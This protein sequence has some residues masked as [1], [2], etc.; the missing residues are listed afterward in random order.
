MKKIMLL[1]FLILIFGFLAG[2]Q[3]ENNNA[4]A[5]ETTSESEPKESEGL[6]IETELAKVELSETKGIDPIVYEEPDELELFI[7]IF[8]SAIREP[9]I[10]NMAAPE[11]Y[12]K[13]TLEDGDIQYLN[14]WLGDEEETASLMNAG[15][16]HTLYTV[17]PDKKRELVELISK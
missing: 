10:V 7:D 17:T 6:L 5:E 8:A 3:P 11:F 4:K 13:V 9:G 14:L 15:E 1:L 16:T 12:L 2:C